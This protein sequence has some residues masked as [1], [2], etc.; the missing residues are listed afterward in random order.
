MNQIKK[1]RVIEGLT[2]IE[3]AEKLG[4]SHVSVCKWE[5]GQTFPRPGRLKTI[6]DV[7]HTT[8][9]NLLEGKTA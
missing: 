2:Q 8:V 9:E 3:L 7:L 1:A 6:A 4:V 5:N